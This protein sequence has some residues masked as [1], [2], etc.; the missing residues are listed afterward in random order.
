MGS[1]L[2]CSQNWG[3]ICSICCESSRV[4]LP[5]QIQICRVPAL[6]EWVGYWS[7]LWLCHEVCQGLDIL[8]WA[9]LFLDSCFILLW[10]ISG[11]NLCWSWLRCVTWA[12][13]KAHFRRLQECWV[14]S[15]G[16]NFKCSSTGDS[17]EKISRLILALQSVWGLENLI[18]MIFSSFCC[19]L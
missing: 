8:F 12:Q 13:Q 4:S 9:P 14:A 17:M 6:K 1:S 2:L 11:K 18:S 3:K 19:L 5:V 15:K 10:L 7:A 16:Q